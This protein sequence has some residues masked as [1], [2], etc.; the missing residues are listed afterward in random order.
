MSVK[1]PKRGITLQSRAFPLRTSWHTRE[2]PS[3]A[4]DTG[5]LA[6]LAGVGAPA[7]PRAEGTVPGPLPAPQGPQCRSRDADPAS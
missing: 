5:V 3:F 6:G 1:R 4:G 2:T 7:A